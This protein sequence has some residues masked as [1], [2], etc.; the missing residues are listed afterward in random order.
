MTLAANSLG[1][2]STALSYTGGTTE[3]ELSN[4]LISALGS[5]GW[6]THDIISE[7]RTILRAPAMDGESY[8]YAEINLTGN[9]IYLSA[10]E[11]WDAVLHSGLNQTYFGTSATH[12]QRYD[13]TN[14]GDLFIFASA[15]HLILLSRTAGDVW[16]NTDNNTF[17]AVLEI[18]RD[19]PEEPAGDYPLVLWTTGSMFI[20]HHAHSSANYARCACLPR[21]T[22]NQTSSN[23]WNYMAI[24]TVVGSTHDLA[25]RLYNVLPS[26]SNPMSP[27]GATQVYTPYLVDRRNR[28]VRGR[29]FGLKILP[30]SIGSA[31]DKIN[32]RVN[33]EMFYDANGSFTHYHHILTT[34]VANGR[35][36]IPE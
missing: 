16:G 25:A 22:G 31:M 10:W 34:A 21:D 28:F 30:L 15:R 23:A 8:K 14:G 19:N 18:A 5:M 20:G 32:V 7:T 4:A 29:V 35:F 9:Y 24:S 11:S 1:Q 36:A 13:L 2:N 12:H 3:A 6:E 27:T 26:G 17:T 33:N